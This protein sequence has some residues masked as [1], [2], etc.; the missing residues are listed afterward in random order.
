MYIYII[1]KNDGSIYGITTSELQEELNKGR[2][3]NIIGQVFLN[4]E[5]ITNE[6]DKINTFNFNDN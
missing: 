3:L 2:N 6:L 5:R 4:K 1:R